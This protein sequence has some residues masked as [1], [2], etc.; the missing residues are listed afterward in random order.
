ML[1]LLR[2]NE[3]FFVDKVLQLVK[4]ELTCD[5]IEVNENS[6]IYVQFIDLDKRNVLLRINDRLVCF[7]E[8]NLVW[9]QGG[10]FPIPFYKVDGHNEELSLQTIRFIKYEWEVINF[11][12]M[13]LLQGKEHIGNF[14]LAETNKLRNLEIAKECGFII[15]KTIIT[16]NAEFVQNIKEK[17]VIKPI[18]ESFPFYINNIGY[19]IFTEKLD[20]VIIPKEFFPSLIQEE[21]ERD[22]EIRVFVILETQEFFAMAIRNNCKE[23]LDYRSANS[24]NR[25]FPYKLEYDVCLKLSCFMEKIGLDTASFDLIRNKRGQYV[26]LEVNPQGNIEMLNRCGY[27]LEKRFSQIIINKYKRIISS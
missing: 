14:F 7:D 20:K 17:K 22:I 27:E 5:I 1:L 11:Y 23:T 25:F 13:K 21:I 4:M 8:I 10:N 12:L 2:K 6:N 24:R 18:G 15:P 26:F 9:Y 3:D 16:Q 19:R